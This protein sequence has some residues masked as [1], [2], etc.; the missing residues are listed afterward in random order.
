MGIYNL[1]KF[2]INKC[3]KDAIYKINLNTLQHKTIVIDTSIYLYKFIGQNRLIEHFYLLI[4]IL[5]YNKITPI[6]VFDGKPPP[7]KMDI[8]RQRKEN[9]KE[10][11]HQYY[12]LQESINDETT[13]EEKNSIMSKMANL[14]KE[15]IRI[16]DS[17]IK[18][19]K[20][21]LELYGVCYIEASGEADV[22]CSN[23]V[24]NGEAWACLSDDMDMFLYG[25]NRVL[26]FISLLN[27]SV[28]IYDT[29][30]IL[31]ELNMDI[32]C[33]RYFTIPCGTDYN[34][35]TKIT[36]SQMMKHYTSYKNQNS[37]NK[38]FDKYLIENNITDDSIYELCDMFCFID[39]NIID[40]E[41]IHNFTKN[42]TKLREFLILYGFIF[43]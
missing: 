39:K 15:F 14:K 13:E 4:S 7:E 23:M 41:L 2:L 10:A 43:I 31:R 8:L 3:S 18:N 20:T 29:A 5:L 27:H 1:N 16:S 17:D 40:N 25:C 11:K 21:L 9:K 28:I 24:I 19:V 37:E 22:V 6:F 32:N 34:I 30:T 35:N 38:S 36:L 42:V 33:F 26:R 12:L